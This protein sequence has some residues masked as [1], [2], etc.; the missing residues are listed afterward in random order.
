[1]K[2]ALCLALLLGVSILAPQA[3]ESAYGSSAAEAT[4]TAAQDF[5]TGTIILTAVANA[6]DSNTQKSLALSYNRA[7]QAFFYVTNF[8]TETLNSFTL[9]Q[10]NSASTIRYCVAPAGFKSNSTMLC[11]DNT[12]A[13]LV[14][15]GTSL[16][17]KSLTP[18]LPKTTTYA[19]S[20]T[21]ANG[22]GDTVG[23]KVGPANITSSVTNS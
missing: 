9:T 6:T 15:S 2:R 7:N 1:M 16:L 13:I 20:S 14:G 12:N 23:I 5:G 18:A 4:N 19:F 3:A 11:T 17:N 10:T 22:S 21:R 8:G